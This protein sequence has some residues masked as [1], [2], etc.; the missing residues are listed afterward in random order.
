MKLIKSILFAMLAASTAQSA[1]VAS[2][3]ASPSAQYADPA[4]MASAHL[5]YTD[6]TLREVIHTS[7]GSDTVRIRLSN[8]FNPNAVEIGA[9][10]IALR[11]TASGIDPNTDRTLTFGGLTDVTIPPNAILLSDPIALG[12]PALGDIVISL[13][14]PNTTYAGG[15]HYLGLQTNY[16]GAGDQTSAATINKPTSVSYFAFLAGVDVTVTDPTAATLVTLGDSITDGANS[17]SNT[18]HR[19]PNFLAARLQAAGIN[20]GVADAGISGNRVLHDTL[21]TTSGVNA[22]A[23]LGRDV[24]EQPGAKYL[25]VLEGINDLGQPGTASAPQSETVTA[26]AVIAGLQQ[27]ADRAHEM[28]LQVFGCT[29]TP[30]AVATS[31]NYYSPD[32]EIQREA[33]NAWIRNG[34][35]FD[36]VI[37]FDLATQDPDNP[38]HFLPA[39]DS[40]DHLHPNDAGYKAMADAI[41]ISLFQPPVPTNAAPGE[42]NKKINAR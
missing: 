3:S 1:W 39:Y 25:I 35:A 20:I 37:D 33:V 17:T 8:A 11:T 40:G 13:Y 38:T 42:S 41:D 4:Q 2:W 16:L 36:A 21:T 14:F 15:I 26:D 6:Q 31:A 7:I 32:K 12:V 34:S 5:V 27:I 10:H 28:G 30:F 22:L 23:R 18:N 24:I 29:L 19:W 9:A